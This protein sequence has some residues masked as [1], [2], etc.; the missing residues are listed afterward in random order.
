[1]EELPTSAQVTIRVLLRGL[2]LPEGARA[3]VGSQSVLVTGRAQAGRW[4]EVAIEKGDLEGVVW[5]VPERLN[6]VLEDLRTS[7]R[8]RVAV[9]D[10]QT[11]V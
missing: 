10:Q 3:Q 11:A 9:L 2:P 7:D 8:V 5:A 6:A 1:M 4:G